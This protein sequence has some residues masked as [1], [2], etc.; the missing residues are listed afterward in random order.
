MMGIID[1]PQF[2]IDLL[3]GRS[4]QQDP[5]ALGVP[6]LP[7]TGRSHE[8]PA[9]GLGSTPGWVTRM[10]KWGVFFLLVFTIVLRKRGGEVKRQ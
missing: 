8:V 9:D 2:F 6:L 4:E 5:V 3:Q 10:G 7:V 1:S